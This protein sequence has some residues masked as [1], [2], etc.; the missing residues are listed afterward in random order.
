MCV[1][2]KGGCMAIEDCLEL[3][4]AVGQAITST[5]PRDGDGDAAL[6]AA[7]SAAL[8]RYEESRAPRT[9]KVNE[10]SVQIAELAMADSPVAV[11]PAGAQQPCCCCFCGP[12]L[13]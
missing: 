7:L 8:R 11:S 12:D 10:Q 5:P 13:K 4:N 1:C 2:T 3:A 6:S 9:A